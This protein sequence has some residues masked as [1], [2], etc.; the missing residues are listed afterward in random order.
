MW[1]AGIRGRNMQPDDY[2]IQRALRAALAKQPEVRTPR[3]RWL[4]E[5]RTH[6][7]E[8]H[9]NHDYCF[10]CRKIFWRPTPLRA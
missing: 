1:A 2:E 10:D 7:L 6:R 9:D 8:G 3:E 5:H 4:V